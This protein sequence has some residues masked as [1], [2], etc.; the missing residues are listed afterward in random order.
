MQS[1]PS[2]IL[3]KYLEKYPFKNNFDIGSRSKQQCGVGTYKSLYG[4]AVFLL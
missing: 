3:L 2:E 1:L 4:R